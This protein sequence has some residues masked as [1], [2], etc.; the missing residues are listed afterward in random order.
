MKACRMRMAS[1][2]GPDALLSWLARLMV[3]ITIWPRGLAS[4]LACGG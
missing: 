1:Q 3:M 2:P 4:E